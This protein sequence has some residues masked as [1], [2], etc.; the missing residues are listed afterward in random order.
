M[1]LTADIQ[2]TPPPGARSDLDQPTDV[3]TGEGPDYDAAHAD[4]LANLPT[5][6]RVLSLQRW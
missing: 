5:G 3:I 4:V 6:W 2:K 1:T